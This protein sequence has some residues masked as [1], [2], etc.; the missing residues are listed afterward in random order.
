MP[1][2]PSRELLAAA[3]SGDPEAQN[4]LGRFYSAQSGLVPNG[5]EM[6]ELW[7]RRAADQGLARAKHNLG[8]LAFEAGRDQLAQSWFR[9]AADAG[10][11]PSTVA[12][13][14]I[15]ERAGKKREAARLYEIAAHKGHAD[16][17]DALGR[18]M[19]ELKTADGYNQS[20]RWSEL[21]TAQGVSSAEVRLATIYH[22][23]LGVERD[24]Q[25]A[26]SHFLRAA[27]SGHPGAQFMIGIAYESGA[28][29][30]V[31]LL[32]SA[33]WLT[34]ASAENEIARHY[35]ETKVKPRMT[36]DERVAFEARLRDLLVAHGREIDI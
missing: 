36:R 35:L 14:A 9:A 4:A 24:L 5:V 16:A 12:L 18:M 32:E 25:R 29:V 8:V 17:Q 21:A 11:L 26:A 3:E 13:A 27:R 31:N 10:W 34:L 22:D 30:E 28:G 20:R 2:E 19:L 23:C 6:A 15:L 1:D 7:F 33:F